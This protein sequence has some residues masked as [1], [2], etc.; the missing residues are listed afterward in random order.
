VYATILLTNLV[1]R[2]DGLL[3][4]LFRVTARALPEEKL[5]ANFGAAAGAA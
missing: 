3:R 4:F 5:E 1:T 2:H